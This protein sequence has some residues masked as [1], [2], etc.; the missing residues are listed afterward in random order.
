LRNLQLVFCGTTEKSK[1]RSWGVTNKNLLNTLNKKV[2]DI[3]QLDY[4]IHNRIIKRAHAA[5]SAMYYGYPTLRDPFINYLRETKFRRSMK[6]FSASGDPVFLHSGTLCIPG[7]IDMTG[8]HYLY[9]DASPSIVRYSDRIKDPRKYLLIY[10][11][12]TNNYLSRLSMIFT[13]N[14]WT[15]DSLVA[16]YNFPP[17]KIL[18]VGFG[19]NLDP[20]HGPKDYSN[21]LILI[22]LR[23][24]LEETKGLNLLLKAFSI[25]RKRNKKL[26]LAVVGTTLDPVEGVEYYENFPR[27]KT[28]ELFQEASLFAMPALVESNGMVYPEALSCKTPVLGLERLAFPEFS[29]YGKYGF[30]IKYPDP[31]EIAST[32]LSAMSEPGRLEVMGKEGQRFAVER[33]NWDSVADKMIRAIQESLQT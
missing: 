31:E 18:N 1:S 29:G 7:G 20:Y 12:Y 30:V 14:Q 15:F 23:R 16:E 5:F 32:L 21:G 24:G 28:I 6:K 3:K 11:K 33:Y 26:K 17:N 10:N 19:A 13:F 27:L 22:V 4:N 2:S 25:A 8:N 9:T